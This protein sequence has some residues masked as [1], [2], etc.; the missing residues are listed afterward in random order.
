MPGLDANS[1]GRVAAAFNAIAFEA[2]QS[3]LEEF[4]ATTLQFNAS[5]LAEVFPEQTAPPDDERRIFV[6]QIAGPLDGHR[7][8][9]LR[10]E[11]RICSAVIVKQKDAIIGTES[12]S[13]MGLGSYLRHNN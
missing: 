11:G 7:K 5:Q 8:K 6:D 10:D 12:Y 1:L 13:V 3:P 9:C 4:V 2:V